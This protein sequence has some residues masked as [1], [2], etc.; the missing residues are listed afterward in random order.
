MRYASVA[1]GL[2]ILAS[3]LPPPSQAS[4]APSGKAEFLSRAAIVGWI[5]NYRHKPEPSR[6]PEA[7]RALSEFGSLRDPETAGFFAG[8]VADVLGAN[9]KE[10]ERLVARM[11]PL[12]PPD[13]WLVV[14]AIAYSGLP[15][16]KSLLAR[17]ADK[18]PARRGMID[19]YLTGALPTLD[20]IELDKSPTFLEQVGQHFGVKPKLPPLSYGR[21]PELLDT[22]WGQY[23]AAGQ[24]RPVWRIIAMLPWSKDRD[25]AERLSAGSSAK[26]TL[27][28]NAARYPDVLALIKDMA[29]YQEKDVRPIL[30]EVIHAAE[31]I[32]TSAIRKEQMAAAERLKTGGPGYQR[33]MKL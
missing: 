24:Y 26:Y 14:R 32:E 21:N 9:P 5:D 28:N 15:S 13:Q 2:A 29:M 22:L 23:F 25:S 17:V 3:V 19:A 18:L 1:L 27:A 7:V 10:A 30:A 4:A 6:V 33:D 31:T 12:P 16:W 8:F 20:A 11:L